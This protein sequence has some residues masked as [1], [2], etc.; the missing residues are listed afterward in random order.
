MEEMG[1]VSPRACRVAGRLL[2][3]EISYCKEMKV[4]DWEAILKDLQRETTMD[5]LLFVCGN[6][7]VKSWGTSHVYIRQFQQLYTTVTGRFMDRNDA[8]EVYKVRLS[9]SEREHL[10]FLSSKTRKR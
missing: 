9:E 5:F 6:Y 7:K 2:T 10:F 3:R 8:R 1:A 4:G